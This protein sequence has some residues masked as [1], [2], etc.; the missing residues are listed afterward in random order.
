METEV[1]VSASNSM[2]HLLSAVNSE[3]KVQYLRYKLGLY[4][5][6]EQARRFISHNNR[7]WGR[8]RSKDDDRPVI[9]ADVFRPSQGHIV[10]SYFL[11]ILA[12]RT[13]SRIMAFTTSSVYNMPQVW[14]VYESFN[15]EGFI[16]PEL[17]IEQKARRDKMVRHARSQVR[18]KK[19]LFDLEM[20]GLWNGIDIYETYLRALRKPTVDLD[21]PELWKKVNQAAEAVVFWREFFDH[22]KVAAVVASH[23]CY[24][25]P[26]IVCK[27]AYERKIPVYLPSMR[28]L[29]LADRPHSSTL[30]VYTRYP[31]MFKQ[32][33]YEEQVEA[34]RLAREQ[35]EQRF[36]GEVGVDM[37]Y[38]TK[39][40]YHHE[41]SPQPVLRESD[42]IKVLIASHCFFDNPH[43][44]GDML[45][46]DFYEWLCYLGRI[47]ERTDYDW[48]IKMHP[49]ALPGTEDV[50]QS[51]I[52]QY[53][54]IT[55]IPQTASHHQLVKEGINFV[56]TVFGSVGYE[57][58]ALGVQVITAGGNPRMA[59]DFN[60]HA[61]S[62]EEYENL[63]FNLDKLQK[64]ICLDDL[65]ESYYMHH[66]YVMA[67]DFFL[68]SY[69]RFT[70]ELSAKDQTPLAV[71]GYFLKQLTPKKHET[72]IKKIDEFITSGKHCYFSRGPE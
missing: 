16:I 38:S 71:Y 2:K 3:P 45:F 40:A 24:I 39:S 57:Y 52:Q 54:R 4:K 69:R 72:I 28:A 61:K 15:V 23:D 49:D 11:N 14:C 27:I 22:H 62:L 43:G 41:M 42:R 65:Y 9:L 6:D 51:V 66:Y 59:Y 63:L 29:Y 30:P 10:Y 44:Y 48:Y 7:T 26:G 60:W 17:S 67:D 32:L 68:D 46:V 25:Y 53:P 37:K 70:D 47:A 34:R 58:P 56:L 12:Q 36:R 18:S 31:E 19:D 33:S 55:I 5:F 20:D 50:I 21:D 35:L 13:N 1:D 64:K 8:V